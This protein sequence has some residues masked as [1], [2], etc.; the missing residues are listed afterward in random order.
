GGR[1]DRV[2]VRRAHDAVVRLIEYMDVGGAT[3]W[4][5]DQVVSQREMLDALSRRYG[6]IEPLPPHDSGPSWAPAERFRLPDGTT[7]G[8]IASVTA[9]FCLICDRCRLTADGTWLLCL[10]DV[11]G[12]DQIDPLI[13]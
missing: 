3:R 7:F 13:S 6:R 1:T 8:V 10:S 4:S 2:D 5:M 12:V 11:R 9:P